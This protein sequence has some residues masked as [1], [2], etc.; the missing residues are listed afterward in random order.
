MVG[1]DVSTHRV[2]F[3]VIR[4]R[5]SEHIISRCSIVLCLRDFLEVGFW[6]YIELFVENLAK[7]GIDIFLHKFFRFEVSE[8]EI[9]GSEECLKRIRDYI[10]VG[11]PSGKQLTLGDENI[12]LEMEGKSD[13]CEV[14]PTNEGTTY[15]GQF[16][17]WFFRVCI[18][19]QFRG[20]ELE[21]SISEKLQAFVALWDVYD[22]FI[23]DR[24]VNE[25]ETIIGDIFEWNLKRRYE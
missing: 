18:E 14:F 6:V 23:Q 1:S 5:F 25:G 11:I 20:Y 12:V 19:K 10:R 21:N 9:E 2:G 15:I 8:V 22:I 4:T 7:C 17:L 3:A 13:G 24:A 16:S